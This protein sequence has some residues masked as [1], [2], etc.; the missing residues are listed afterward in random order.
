M[1]PFAPAL[2]A[3]ILSASMAHA[4]AALHIDQRTVTLGDTRITEPVFRDDQGREV[5]LRGWNVSG[6]VKLASRGFKPFE[7]REDA[8]LGFELMKRHTGANLVRFTLAWEGTHP[9]PDQI[10]YAYVDALIEQ[11][12]EAFQQKIHIFL[13]YHTDL[14]SRYLFHET[15]QYTGNG[16][17]EWIIAGGQYPKS[18]CAPVC[19][20]WGQ[21]NVTDAAVRL[22]Y[23]NFFN[24]SP[25]ATALG[26]RHVQNEFLW[27]MRQVLQYVK[28]KL[29]PE[30][31]EWI[32]GVQPIN[33]P[34]YGYGHR[35][36]AA[37]FDNTRLWPFYQRTRQLM[38]DIG[39]QDKWVYAEPMVFWDTNAGFFAPATG[40]HYLQQKPGS[41]F[42]F[43]P[44]FYDA[45]R[46][47]VT[48]TNKTYNGEYFRN[49]DTIRDEARFLG[50]PAVVGEFGMWLKDQKGGARDHARIVKGTYQGMEMS[51]IGHAAKNRRPD[52]YT[53]PLSGTQWHWDINKDNH[54]EYQNGN[55][56]KLRT[57]GD[58]WNG[59]D[60]SVIKGDTLTVNA[61]GVQRAFPRFVDGNIVSFHYNDLAVDGAGNTLD[62]AEIR[63]RTDRYF[64]DNRFALL[65]W[66]G[67]RDHSTEV[68]LP[69]GFS[70]A[71][72]SLITDSE[73]RASLENDARLRPEFSDGVTGYRLAL[74]SSASGNAGD[75]H[76]ALI[77][78]HTAASQTT[79]EVLQSQLAEQIAH[80]ENPVFL[81]GKMAGL[82]Y[83][84]YKAPE[85][86]S[87]TEAITLT[88]SE[89]HFL[90]F[91]WVT[92]DWRGEAA[93][94]IFQKDKPVMQGIAQ[95]SATLF[96]LIGARDTFKVCETG[97]TVQCSR[98]LHFD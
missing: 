95:G 89:N 72:T 59:E 21:H 35:N 49:L 45:A 86:N 23:R 73:V 27:Q 94:T 11:M 26:E 31:F 60:F 57:K 34:I 25:I 76:F 69:N 19:F 6:S 40:G 43:A 8:A 50:I 68:F 97:A 88:A 79:L 36:R 29:T 9:G 67:G 14:Y 5:Y 17:P 3:S 75:L 77:V 39:W 20:A 85:E 37:E 54:R 28:S 96:S 2:L 16:A 44:H 65:I 13:D 12:R 82:N 58:G 46:M 70:P 71:D 63:T 87:D 47:G 74:A 51:D 56:K 15:S 78:N 33:E 98:T 64:A 7:S 93:V 62:W 41:G 83:P 24:N 53:A 30:E 4:G 92:L 22:G 38:N 80:H 90:F 61:N 52:F 10:D 66:Q 48:N 1:K 18:N 55:L 32:T 91:R 42:V 84:E 81:R